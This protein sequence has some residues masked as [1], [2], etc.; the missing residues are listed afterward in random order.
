MISLGIAGRSSAEATKDSAKATLSVT[1]HEPGSK[2]LL[3][4]RAWVQAGNRRLFNP[5]TKTCTPYPKDRSF[6]CDGEFSILAPPGKA[7]IHVERGK[8]Y[9]PVDQEAV[10]D[11]DTPQ[12]VAIELKRWVNMVQE[13]WYSADLHVHFGN[14][15]PQVL[16]Q[17]ALA[18]D[19]NFLPVF[20]LWTQ[21][22]EQWPK[23]Q[24]GPV[25]QADAAHTVTLPNEEIER[26]GG[27]PF[28][29]VGALFI[30][31]L[32]KP[33]FVPRHERH[34]PCDATLQRLAKQTSPECVIDT[35]KPSWAEN[36]VGVALGL[37]DSVQ[38]CHNHYHREATLAPGYGMAGMLAEDEKHLGKDELFIR[39]NA[40]YY[41]W[42]NCGFRLSVSGGS[43]MGVMPV[44]LGYSRTYAKIEGPLSEASYLKAV[45]DGRTFA[46]SGPML[47]LTADGKDP[48][49]VIEWRTGKSQP[50]QVK[51][52]LRSIQQIDAL[53]LVYN[54]AVV[55][56]AALPGAPVA[57]VMK[58]TIELPLE[59]PRSGWV[60]ARAIF[61]SPPGHLRQAHTSPVYISVDGKPRAFS[62][63]AEYMV[64]WIDEILKVSAQPDRYADPAGRLEA[65]AIFKEARRIYE[66]IAKTA[67]EAWGD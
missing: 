48:G 15:E 11:G 37:F 26:I 51:A 42:L 28:E 23:W 43:A 52:E 30:F 31:G 36:V 54:G 8:E 49:A 21:Y 41:R 64:A 16:K 34:Y 2:T 29:S 20:S 35:D 22:A 39:T 67:K 12:D 1:I 3:P 62:K 46:T 24:T 27:R 59:P 33:V 5:L 10:V 19:V 61:Q 55:K 50:I 32:A 25:A 13:G 40:I 44:P 9:W 14:G 6:S 57:G 65:Q 18:D 53:E 60:A 17:L 56:S 7:V 45:R 38:V 58:Q 66:G 63:D 47:V 4:C